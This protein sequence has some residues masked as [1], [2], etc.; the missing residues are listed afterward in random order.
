MDSWGRGYLDPGEESQGRVENRRYFDLGGWN[1]E[2]VKIRACFD[3]ASG[4]I[5]DWNEKRGEKEKED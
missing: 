5:Y 3:P 2:R 1:H 4:D